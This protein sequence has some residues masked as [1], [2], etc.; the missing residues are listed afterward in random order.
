MVLRGRRERKPLPGLG[1][2]A[3][4][5]HPYRDSAVL[6]GVLAVAIVVI[7]LVTGVNLGTALVVAPL[8]FVA[9]TAW[10]WWRFSQR[11]RREQEEAAA[12]AEAAAADA[13]GGS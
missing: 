1:D 10:S 2:I 12:A 9:A 13:D 6:H 8:Y 4:P 7:A 5:E 3:I 11:I